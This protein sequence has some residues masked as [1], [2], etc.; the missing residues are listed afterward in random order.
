MNKLP[1]DICQISNGVGPNYRTRDSIYYSMPSSQLKSATTKDSPMITA[2]LSPRCWKIRPPGSANQRLVWSVCGERLHWLV[3]P[4]PLISDPC[5]YICTL[6]YH[7]HQLQFTIVKLTVQA[8]SVIG[9]IF[10]TGLPPLQLSQ[11]STPQWMLIASLS[12]HL[13]M[14]IGWFEVPSRDATT[15]SGNPSLDDD[16]ATLAMRLIISLPAWP[17]HSRSSRSITP[18][19]SPASFLGSQF[20]YPVFLLPCISGI[21]FLLLSQL[22][23]LPG[24]SCRSSNGSSTRRPC[25]M[26]RGSTMPS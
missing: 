8:A 26:N 18:Y 9:P 10:G 6:E 24:T 14:S 23:S 2:N 15:G 3:R 5:I 19:C 17:G 25:P 7:R 20:L 21:A 22:S 16:M 13:T 11:W 12:H 1:S 4:H